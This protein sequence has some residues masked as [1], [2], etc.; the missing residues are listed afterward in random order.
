MK[1]LFLFLL[2]IFSVTTFSQNLLITPNRIV[3]NKNSKPKVLMN[4]VN[5]G[6]DTA[7]Y[8][9]SFINYRMTEDGDFDTITEED[10]LHMF[11]EKYL[12]VFPRKVKLAPGEPQV[13]AVQVRKKSNMKLGEYRSHAYFRGIEKPKEALGQDE[14]AGS[15]TL[16]FKLSLTPIYG[17]TIP[18]I[19][20][21]IEDNSTVDI[22]NQKYVRDNMIDYVDLNLIR[23]GDTSFY[24][25]VQVEYIPVSGKSVIVGRISGIGVYTDITKRKVRIRLNNTDVVNFLSGELIIRVIVKDQYNR[26][27]VVSKAIIKL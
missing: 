2:S 18:V 5:T 11:S 4:I 16:G 19:F 22:E 14:K 8:S 12:R 15:D 7:T 23:Y 25:S 1:T 9:I 26:E 27:S 20:R 21:N 6:E 3:F 13:V 10:S 24:G 17:M